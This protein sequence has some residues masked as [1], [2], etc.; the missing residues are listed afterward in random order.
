MLSAGKMPR[1]QS[2]PVSP[3]AAPMPCELELMMAASSCSQASCMSGAQHFQACGADERGLHAACM[4]GAEQVHRHVGPMSEAHTPFVRSSGSLK[5]FG[6]FTD[7][8]GQGVKFTCL[9][10]VRSSG[11]LRV[12]GADE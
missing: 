2:M 10:H 11:S 3:K 8:W 4:S 1:A 5:V 12:C 7:M 9:L 6:A